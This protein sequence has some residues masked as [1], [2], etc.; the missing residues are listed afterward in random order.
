MD[1]WE[2]F[3]EATLSVKEEFY[4]KLNTEDIIDEDYIHGK[5]F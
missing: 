4:S 1:D 2:R 5:R 3:N